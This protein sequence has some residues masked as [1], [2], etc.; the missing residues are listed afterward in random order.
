M[1]NEPLEQPNTEILEPVT[2]VGRFC[3][4]PGR[5]QVHETNKKGQQC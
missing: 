4:K 3:A 5:L 1:T 2:C